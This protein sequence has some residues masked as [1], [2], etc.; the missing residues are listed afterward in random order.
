MKVIT[1]IIELQQE[2]EKHRVENKT[3]AL[4]PTMGYL[5]DGHL[6][7]AKA[8]RENNDV[9]VMSDFV[10][11]TQFGPNEDF[12]SYPRDLARDEQM[13]SN[14]GVDYLFAP[15]VEEIYPTDGGIRFEAG[16]ASKVLCGA[17]RPIHFNGVL[18]V[19]SKLFHIIQPTNAYFGEKDAQQLAL[20]KMMARDYNFP[21]NICS[22]P[23]VREED[24]LAKSSRNVFLTEEERKQA[25]VLQ[26]ALQRAKEEF[27]Y[28]EEENQAIQIA[29]S[30][31]ENE[32]SGKI[33][34]LEM[35]SYPDLQNISPET[36]HYLLAVAVYFSQ[37]RLIDNILFSKKEIE[38]CLK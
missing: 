35:R 1:T 36:S 29:K 19:V 12:E 10:N 9:V 31:I 24:G 5:H 18:Q 20:I 34:Y 17:S 11:P 25:P 2:L 28:S 4:V 13:A 37:V 38:L 30:I 33:D 27:L 3:I 6:T 8:A 14:E 7:L 22:V 21:V 32:T 15:S 16:P 26:K 23:I